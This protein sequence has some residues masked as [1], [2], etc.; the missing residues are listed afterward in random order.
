MK[1]ASMCF[2]Y[3]AIT[4]APLTGTPGLSSLEKTAA[5]TL[6]QPPL[7]SSNLVNRFLL[8]PGPHARTP[9]PFDLLSAVSSNGPSPFYG[10]A[11]SQSLSENFAL[12]RYPC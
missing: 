11:A 6:D 7:V 9:F 2:A 12:I 10:S 8:C 3:T 4:G 1:T 5:H